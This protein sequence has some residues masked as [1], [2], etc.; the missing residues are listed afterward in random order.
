MAG[1]VH[2]RVLGVET[3]GD[4]DHSDGMTVSDALTA[5]GAGEPPAHS[6]VTRNGRKANMTDR[7]SANDMVVVTPRISNG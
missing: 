2:V 6:T 7:V 1:K 5:A 4:P 3:R